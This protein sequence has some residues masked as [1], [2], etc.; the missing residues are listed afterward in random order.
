MKDGSDPSYFLRR[1]HVTERPIKTVKFKIDKRGQKEHWNK[2][3]NEAK[4]VTRNMPRERQ[5]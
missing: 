4:R 1:L 5:S 2:G 3:V